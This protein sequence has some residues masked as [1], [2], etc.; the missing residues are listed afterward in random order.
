MAITTEAELETA[1]AAWMARQGDT[2]ITSVIPDWIKL[3]ESRIQLGSDHPQFPSEPLRT[4]QMET[5]ATASV[6][7]EYVALPTDFLEPRSLKFNESPEVAVKYVTPQ[8]FAEMGASSTS[9]TPRVYTIMGSE[10]RF[11]PVPSGTLTAEILYYAS[12]PPLEDN[13]DNWLLLTAPNIYL[14]GSLLEGMIYTQNSD[15][16][17]LCAGLFSAAVN[18]L[19]KTEYRAKWGG[20]SLQMRPSMVPNDGPRRW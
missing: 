3:C 18:G 13:T 16:A 2:L 4:R 8:Q 19:Q 17:L 9:G 5:R 20:A 1:I 12:L 14:Y 6:S 11:G 10:F 7:S 15:R